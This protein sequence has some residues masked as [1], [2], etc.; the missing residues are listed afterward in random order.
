MFGS[1]P[2]GYVAHSP[3]QYLLVHITHQKS[4][5]IGPR[6]IGTD[7]ENSSRSTILIGSSKLRKLNIGSEIQNYVVCFEFSLGFML[8]GLL[9]SCFNCETETPVGSST[10]PHRG[11]SGKLSFCFRIGKPDPQFLS[12]FIPFTP[13]VSPGFCLNDMR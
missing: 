8:I 4:R 13:P 9:Q 7:S 1:F 5:S 12:V 2:S 6:K 11:V 3:I 10:V